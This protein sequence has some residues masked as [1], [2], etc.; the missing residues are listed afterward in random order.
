MKT[1]VTLFF[2]I[3]F[4][5]GCG[6]DPK[7][8][9]PQKS[10]LAKIENWA[11]PGVQ[12]Q[13]SGA[14]FVYRNPLSI[15]DTLISVYSPQAM[16]TQIHESYTTE[17][18]LAGMREKAEIIVQANQNITLE[19]GGLHVMLMNLKTDLQEPDSV[20]ISLIFNQAGKVDLTLPVISNKK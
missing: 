20:T 10:E 1:S 12:G 13:M 8:N 19:Q 14:Y 3:L 5:S 18:D 11:R 15:A 9:S 6:D 4:F 2:A 16:M 17:D 7:K